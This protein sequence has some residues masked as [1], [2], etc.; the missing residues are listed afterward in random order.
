MIGV[1]MPIDDNRPDLAEKWGENSAKN[2][3]PFPNRKSGQI[4]IDIDQ[5]NHSRP[6][7]S[8]DSIL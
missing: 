3:V 1:D 8:K 2:E 7:V 5:S 4:L 6:P